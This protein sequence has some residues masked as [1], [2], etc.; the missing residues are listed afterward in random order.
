MLDLPLFDQR[1]VHVADVREFER[2]IDLINEFHS[3]RLFNQ[4]AHSAYIVCIVFEA[5]S[6]SCGW[7]WV[8]PMVNLRH[9]LEILLTSNW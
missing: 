1:Q 9:K 5:R 3:C 4:M 7:I 2:A 8:L 6:M